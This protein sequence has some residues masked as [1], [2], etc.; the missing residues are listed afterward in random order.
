MLV[1]NNQLTT[2]THYINFQKDQRKQKLLQ[3]VH[4]K[5]KIN[6]NTTDDKGIS[7]LKLRQKILLFSQSEE[8]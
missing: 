4:S 5:G 7:K 3:L 2:S 6:T 8:N 1:W